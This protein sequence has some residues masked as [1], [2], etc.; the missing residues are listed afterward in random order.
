MDGEGMGFVESTVER[1][2][3]RD[4]RWPMEAR[5]SKGL[6]EEEPTT[7]RGRW[8]V[9]VRASPRRRERSG[10]CPY[11]AEVKPKTCVLRRQVP[12]LS[13][14]RARVNASH[15]GQPLLLC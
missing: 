11:S 6:G 15:P 1:D 2:T 10:P 14:A 3:R 4:R 8:E 12:L 13:T 9:D 5:I 7:S